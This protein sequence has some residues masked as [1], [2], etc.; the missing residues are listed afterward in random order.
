MARIVIVGGSLGGLRAT[1]ALF[2][3]RLLAPGR[4]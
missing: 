2:T 1:E 4:A 3:S